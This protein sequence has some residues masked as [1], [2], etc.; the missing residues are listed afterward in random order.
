MKKSSS[1]LFLI[2]LLSNGMGFYFFY[3]LHLYHIKVEM[4]E[5]LKSIPEEKLEILK[6]TPK[7]YEEA[8]VEDGEIKV[9]GR[10]YDVA[11]ISKLNGILKVYCLH[12]EKED[13][14]FALLDE[15]VA[16]PIKNQSSI[17]SEVFEFLSLV[18]I[19]TT[20]SPDFFTAES[21]S[22]QNNYYHFSLKTILLELTTP[23]PRPASHPLAA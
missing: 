21:D 22:E 13:N 9:N 17:P 10:M 1:I 23:P 8:I 14:L 19:D 6:L 15:L 16:K 4:K 7:Q 20:V 12:D 18:F 5:T 3:C 2:L 11:R